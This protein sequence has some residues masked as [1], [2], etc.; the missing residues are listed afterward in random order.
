MQ[1]SVAAI[2]PYKSFWTCGIANTVLPDGRRLGF[3]LFNGL[4]KTK[5]GKANS[6]YIII[7]GKTTIL[8][9]VTITGHGKESAEKVWRFTSNY[10]MKRGPDSSNYK[11]WV[12][13]EF[14]PLKKI[15]IQRNVGIMRVNN[16]WNY[17]YYSGTIYD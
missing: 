15:P 9:P 3:S 12:E 17:G 13:L 1:D 7:D 16:E 6:D 10:T 2:F 5:V 4:G 11:S 14:K 8:W